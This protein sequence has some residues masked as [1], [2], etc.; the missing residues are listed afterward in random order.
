MMPMTSDELLTNMR[1][2]LADEREAIRKLDTEALTRATAKKESMLKVVLDAPKEERAVF[3]KALGELK[4]DL[5]RNLVLLAHARD[6]V[7]DAA[8]ILGSR[9]ARPRLDAKL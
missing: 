9:G 8:L 1:R 7:R 4:V 3:A 5:R 2:A 6:Y